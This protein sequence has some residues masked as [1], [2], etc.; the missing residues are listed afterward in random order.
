VPSNV[1][2]GDS[3]VA[4]ALPETALVKAEHVEKQV[5]PNIPPDCFEGDAHESFVLLDLLGRSGKEKGDLQ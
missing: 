5:L 3:E 1:Q 4:P 2:A